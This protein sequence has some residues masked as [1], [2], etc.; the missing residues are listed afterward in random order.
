MYFN[1][2]HAI[3]VSITDDFSQCSH[4]QDDD[5]GSCNRLEPNNIL[6]GYIDGLGFA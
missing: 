2:N 4:W 5:T 6:F 3:F 1:E